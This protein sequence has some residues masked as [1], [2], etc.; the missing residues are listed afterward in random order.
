MGGAGLNGGRWR[1][2][3]GTDPAVGLVTTKEQTIYSRLGDHIFLFDYQNYQ[4]FLHTYSNCELNR[5]IGLRFGL[6]G[7]QGGFLC[8]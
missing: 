5:L 3:S 4:P 1:G 2:R 8:Q 6:A 7:N